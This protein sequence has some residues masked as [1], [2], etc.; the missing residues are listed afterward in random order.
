MNFLALNLL[1]AI[2][3]TFLLG[4]FS[5][6][7]VLFGFLMGFL[8]LAAAQPFLASER[9]VRSVV[10]LIRFLTVYAYE[11][12]VANLQLARDVLRPTLPFTPG[13]IRYDASTLSTVERVVLANMISLTPGTL[14]VDYGEEGR[15]L[16]IHSLYAQDPAK[17]C[18]GIDLLAGLIDGVTGHRPPPADEDEEVPWKR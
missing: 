2:V 16:Y 14:T 17:L 4:S 1:L 8:V 7:S 18:S 9:Y 15:A 13:F 6:G 10:G 12:L 3:W 11:L 5:I